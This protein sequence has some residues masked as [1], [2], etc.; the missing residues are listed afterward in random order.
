MEG[1]V[2]RRSFG[3]IPADWAPLLLS[4]KGEITKFMNN[5]VKQLRR[6]E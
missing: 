6:L 4:E 3:L 2:L 1:E 5:P